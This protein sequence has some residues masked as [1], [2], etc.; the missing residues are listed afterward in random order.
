MGWR[1]AKPYT[2]SLLS[3]FGMLPSF[4][5]SVSEKK[6]SLIPIRSPRVTIRGK[7]ASQGT[8]VNCMDSLGI[9]TILNF[10]FHIPHMKGTANLQ[11]QTSL[12]CKHK[13]VD[14]CCFPP[15]NFSF[16]S[17][18][19]YKSLAHLHSYQTQLQQDIKRPQ[20]VAHMDILKMSLCYIS[21]RVTCLNSLEPI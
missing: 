4:L 14:I 12:S 13:H 8:C 10:S 19:C 6:R 1:L 5:Y 15:V 21:P 17:V 9:H 18:P 3:L 2:H 11:L 16:K 20:T 7:T